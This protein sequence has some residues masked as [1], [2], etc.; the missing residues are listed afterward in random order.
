L[1]H[2]VS[3]RLPTSLLFFNVVWVCDCACLFVCEYICH[4][5]FR[6]ACVMCM[7]GW[8]VVPLY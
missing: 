8:G 2:I 1:E 3:L 7:Y 6:C 4:R 5:E